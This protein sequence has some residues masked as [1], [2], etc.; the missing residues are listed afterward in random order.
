MSADTPAPYRALTVFAVGFL[1]LDGVL[2]GWAGF[3]L[4]R[5]TLIL[6]GVVCSVAGLIVTLLW[7]RHRRSLMEVAEGRLA[8]RRQAEDLRALL[9]EHHLGN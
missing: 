6:W 2:L 8:M 7:R 4:H 9:R 5:A 1:F 3:E